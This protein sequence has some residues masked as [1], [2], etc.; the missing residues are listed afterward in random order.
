MIT[1][2]SFRMGSLGL[3]PNSRT[4]KMLIYSAEIL[5]GVVFKMLCQKF[6]MSIL[7]IRQTK[8]NLNMAFHV[9][10]SNIWNAKRTP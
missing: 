2:I 1:S 7:N 4:V 9:R 5:F 6:F 8:I 10:Q 3:F